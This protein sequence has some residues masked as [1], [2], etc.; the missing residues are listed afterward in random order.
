MMDLRSDTVTRPTKEMYS[1]MASAKVGDDVFQE[2]PTVNVLQETAAE[3]FAKEA[4][5]FVPTGTMGNLIAAIA[6]SEDGGSFNEMIVGNKQH[7][8]L[9]EVGSMARLAGVHSWVLNNQDDG[10]LAMEEIEGAV[11]SEDVHHPK[12]RMISLENTHNSCG[13]IPLKAQYIDK[14]GAIATRFKI[15]L[16][17]DGARIFNAS[18]ALNQ[19]VSRICKSADSVSFCLSKGLSAPC[20]SLLVG[21][22]DFIKRARVAR[23]ALGGGMRQAGVLAACGLV[24]LNVVTKRLDEDHLKAR[25]LAEGLQEMPNI[26]IDPAKVH[27]NILFFDVSNDKSAELVETLEKEHGVLVGAYS[28]KK[29]RAVT[30][31]DVPMQNIPAILDSFRASLK[32]IFK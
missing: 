24:S 10:T 17:I 5:L 26:T 22:N 18:T 9:Y 15:S 30:H 32:K 8:Y 2:D 7:T 16:H 31:N 1:A 20:G 27:T 19:P 6:H 14:V 4:A 3:M 23:K 25:K 29:V 11:R 21:S 13:G 12:T 28:T